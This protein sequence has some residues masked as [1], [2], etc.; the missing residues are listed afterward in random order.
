MATPLGQ[1]RSAAVRTIAL[2]H[3][4]PGLNLAAAWGLSVWS[5]HALLMLAWVFSGC[6]CSL[7]QPKDLLF[8]INKWP[9]SKRKVYLCPASNDGHMLMCDRDV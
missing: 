2:E 8:V 5:L 4:G 9:L 1:R 6:L 3:K 7:S